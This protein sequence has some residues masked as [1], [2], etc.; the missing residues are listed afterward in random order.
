MRLAWVA[1][2]EQM[3]SK[4]VEAGYTD[5]QRAHFALFRYPT[6]ADMRP[7]QLAEQAGLSRQSTNDLLRQ[8]EA[9]GYIRLQ[10]DPTDRRAKLIA[11]TD[12][13]SGLME[14]LRST[15]QQVSEE[16]AAVVGQDRI[17]AVRA[18]LLELLKAEIRQIPTGQERQG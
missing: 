18:T 2:R 7:S 11:L 15:A 10:P 5:L 1:F 8:L 9:K 16:W 6:I 12:R 14:L 13:G 4:V 3:Y 17:V